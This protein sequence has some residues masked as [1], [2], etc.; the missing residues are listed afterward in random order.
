M[1]FMILYAQV[2]ELFEG[3]EYEFRIIAV[4]NIGESPPSDPSPMVLVEEQP[5]MAKTS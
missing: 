1:K 2:L 4:N 5:G 3:K